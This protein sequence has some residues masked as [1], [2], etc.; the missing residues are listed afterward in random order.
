VRDSLFDTNAWIALTFPAHPL[1]VP[2]T[3]VFVATSAAGR[4]VLFCRGTQQSYLRLLTNKHVLTPL[5]LSPLTNHDA[6]LKLDKHMADAAVGLV[7]E[8]RTIFPR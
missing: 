6:L 2:A 3:A 1:H 5:G 7:D 4:R 8:P